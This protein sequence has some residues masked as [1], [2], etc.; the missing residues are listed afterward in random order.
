[1]TSSNVVEYTITKNNKEVGHFRKHSMCFKPSYSELLKYQPLNDHEIIAWG[2]DEDDE[3]WE[4]DPENLEDF[5]KRCTFE[6]E[7]KDYFNNKK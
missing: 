1:M 4:D 3:G 7:I 2:Y 5:L 6:K